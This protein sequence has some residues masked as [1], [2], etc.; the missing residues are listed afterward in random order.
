MD[1]APP[2]L[3]SAVATSKHIPVQHEQVD[4]GIA[5][6]Q[7]RSEPD[8]WREFQK[9]CVGRCEAYEKSAMTLAWLF[10]L[11]GWMAKK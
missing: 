3:V 1:L 11:G 2:R 4:A 7:A 10:F 6:D 8:A 5:R 9:F